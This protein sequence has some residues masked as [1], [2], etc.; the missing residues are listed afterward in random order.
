MSEVQSR[1]SAPRGG[2]GSSTHRGRGGF[3]RPSRGRG[4]HATYGESI[5]ATSIDEN[6]EVIQL[7][8]KYGDKFNTLHDMFPQW[9]DVDVVMA[10][11]ETGGDLEL[12]VE[13][14]TE[15][16]RIDQLSQ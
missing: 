4:G 11:Q 6:D 15:G 16:I 3:S 14:I 8:R 2:R 9:A 7:K 12:T 13:G 5:V 10:L 1:P